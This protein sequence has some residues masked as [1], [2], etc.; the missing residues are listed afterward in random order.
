MSN[1][2]EIHW[3]ILII[4]TDWMKTDLQNKCM[5][6]QWMDQELGEDQKYWARM[7]LTFSN[8]EKQQGKTFSN[9]HVWSSVARIERYIAGISSNLRKQ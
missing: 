9:C 5:K 2:E 7:E 4:Y 8:V 6:N 3:R 1:T